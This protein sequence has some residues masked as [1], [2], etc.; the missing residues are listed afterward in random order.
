[1]R[2]RLRIVAEMA[3]GPRVDLFCVEAERTGV[4]EQALAQL[5]GTVGLPR[6]R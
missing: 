6:F 4:R 5:A 1:M 2:Q 3:T